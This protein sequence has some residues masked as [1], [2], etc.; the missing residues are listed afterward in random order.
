MLI[1]R[2]K[3]KE[4][5]FGSLLNNP[6]SLLTV[7]NNNIERVTSFK[8]LG[9]HISNS[10]QWDCHIDAICSK[11]ASRLY[12]LKQLK[13]SGLSQQDLLYFYITSIRSI[14]EY[15]C[16]V[17]HH[18]LTKAQSFRLE[19][20]QK[21]ALRII[22]PIVYDMPYNFALSLADLAALSERRASLGRSFFK[23][24]CQ[25]DNCLHSLLPPPRD[26]EVTSRLRHPSIYPIPITRTK[27]YCSYIQYALSNYQ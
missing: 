25:P 17:W 14:L 4:I 6:P 27:R 2:V 12:F 9:V 11:A 24:V 3:T 8:L 16:V 22:F 10:L 26:R 20:I 18:G 19:A 7:E 13:R 1:N 23:E 5:L 15:A 21:R